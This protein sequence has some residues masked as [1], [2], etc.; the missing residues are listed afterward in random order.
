MMEFSTDPTMMMLIFAGLFA[1]FIDS[2][3]GGGGL[4]TIPALMLS[5]LPPIATLGT[6]KL[7][8]LFGSFSAMIAY[9][10][11]GHVDISKQ[12]GQAFL[13]FLGSII[14]ALVAT[15]IPVAIFQAFLPILLIV[16]A[17]YFALK[18]NLNDVDKQQRIRPVIFCLTMAPLIGFYDGI[19]GPGAGSFYMLAFVTLSGFGI[20]KATAHTKLLNFSSNL[21]AL[22]TF[23]MMGTINIRIG[24]VMGIAQFIGAQL[25]AK[26]AMKT[27][28]KLIKPLLVLVCLI[29]AYKLL[30]S[31]DNPLRQWLHF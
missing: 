17:L 12:F 15:L 22:L 24:I 16:V 14:G 9:A 23:A 4:I 7:Q 25:G 27:G 10:R 21:G 3:A 18:P 19:F 29:L 30:Q 13:A 31:P 5:G 2:I 1:G 26:V 28:A 20:L 11:G 6:N 8:G